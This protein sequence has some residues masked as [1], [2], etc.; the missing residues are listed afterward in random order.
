M[1]DR[2]DRG[3][4]LAS[5]DHFQTAMEEDYADLAERP[6]DHAARDEI[7]H[8]ILAVVRGGPATYLARGMQ[9]AIGHLFERALANENWTLIRVQH[10]G[11]RLLRRFLRGDQVRGLLADVNV[12]A[13]EIDSITIVRDISERMH[14]TQRPAPILGSAARYAAPLPTELPPAKPPPRAERLSDGP[15]A[16]APAPV[17][18]PEAAETSE[19]EPATPEEE[20]RQQQEQTHAEIEQE[21]RGKIPVYMNSY[22]QRGLLT[23]REGEQLLQIYRMDEGG[24]RE[25]REEADRLRGCLGRDT[26][27]KLDR[28]ISEAVDYVVLYLEV[29]DA[30]K[31]IPEERDDALRF[32][33]R[34]KPCVVSTNGDSDFDPVVEEL[35]GDPAVLASLMEMMEGKDQE[36]RMIGAKLPPYG[37]ILRRDEKLAGMLIE[38]SFVD[39]LRTRT[40]DELS[41]ALNDPAVEVRA[42]NAAG[43]KCFLVLVDHLTRPTRFCQETRIVKIKQTMV[44][45]SETAEDANAGRER[46]SQ[47]LERRLNRLYP[48][49][50]PYELGAVKEYGEGLMRDDAPEA[51]RSPGADD[52]LELTEAEASQGVQIARVEVRVGGRYRRIAHKIMPDPDDLDRYVVV[53][54]DPQTGEVA[55]ALRRGSKRYV[56]RNRKGEWEIA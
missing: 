28:T 7:R 18:E 10:E 5:V 35:H 52:C 41:E 27:K 16:T 49:I 55:P 38:E 4:P 25:N 39:D 29:F 46:V 42:T 2:L 43:I 11:V 1:A 45:L 53:Q 13:S 12:R 14:D 15:P 34:H 9:N 22:V 44:E 36:V 31:G 30:L 17:V 24:G 50:T 6:P 37:K 32:L 26:Y 19:A 21:E 51:H 3:E 33:I 54:A 40:P 23:A 20:R 56:E 48:S 8:M 47:F